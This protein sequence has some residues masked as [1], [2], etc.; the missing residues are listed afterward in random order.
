MNREAIYGALFAKVKD[1]EGL[2]TVGRVLRHWERV[3]P[4]EQPALFMTQDGEEPMSRT[5]LAT[6]WRLHVSFYLY[7]HAGNDLDAI[8]AMEINRYL[9]ALQA[10]LQPD[11][12]TGRQTLGGLVDDTKFG[13]KI[14][15][16][17]G[18]LGPQSVAIVP[19]VLT[20]TE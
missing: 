16:D 10:A 6:T 1:I 7:C 13:E 20:I 15:T 19:V 8:P 17:E 11:R 14:E 18:L 4:S 12:V 2:A 3:D 9:D 5:E